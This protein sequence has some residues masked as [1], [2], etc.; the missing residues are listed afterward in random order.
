MIKH[1]ALGPYEATFNPKSQWDSI[2]AMALD[3][4][5]AA[6]Q[7]FWN[8]EVKEKCLMH[9]AHIL[10]ENHATGNRI[11]FPNFHPRSLLQRQPRRRHRLQLRRSGRQARNHN[12]SRKCRLSLGVLLLAVGDKLQDGHRPALNKPDRPCGIQHCNRLMPLFYG[13]FEPQSQRERRRQHSP[14]YL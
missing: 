10:M 14:K 1:V 2:F 13:S 12:W 11:Q 6:A 5:S 7:A 8:E 9:C 4:E 3:E